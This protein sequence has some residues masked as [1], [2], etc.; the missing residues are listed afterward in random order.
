MAHGGARWQAPRMQPVVKKR[1]TKK[2]KKLAKP[3]PKGERKK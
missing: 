2:V 1:G 3:K